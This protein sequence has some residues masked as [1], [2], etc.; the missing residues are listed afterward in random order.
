LGFGFGVNNNANSNDEASW[1]LLLGPR[2]AA[3]CKCQIWALIDINKP[4]PLPNPAD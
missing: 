4:S 1:E 2:K 3:K